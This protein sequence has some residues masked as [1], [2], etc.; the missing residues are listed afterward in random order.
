MFKKV[1]ISLPEKIHEEMAATASDRNISLSY[2]VREMYEDFQSRQVI[3]SGR[4][5]GRKS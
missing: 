5:F 3:R 4:I 1:M 2:L